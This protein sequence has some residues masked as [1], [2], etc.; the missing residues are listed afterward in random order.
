MF[1]NCKFLG[2]SGT[3]VLRLDYSFGYSVV[4]GKI[5]D[6]A[7]HKEWYPHPGYGWA[8]SVS[9]FRRM[10][11]LPVVDI[12]GSADVHFAYS[13]INRTSG[14][15]EQK[16]KLGFQFAK[17]VLEE[18]A[19]TFRELSSLS[20]GDGVTVGYVPVAISHH[21]HG[22][23]EDRQYRTRSN[24]FIRHNFNIKRDMKESKDGLLEFIPGMEQ[25][26]QDIVNCFQ[27]RKEDALEVK[28]ETR[29]WNEKRVV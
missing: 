1:E 2:P 19:A 26:Q 18:S 25:M 29:R 5:I 27:K 21:W 28:S 23:R 16:L 8:M 24:I 13:L 7:R 10:M 4:H 6:Q 22:S 14:R 12:L 11:G 17:H 15:L 20:P 3:E 9:A